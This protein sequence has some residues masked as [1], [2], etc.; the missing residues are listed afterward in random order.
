MNSQLLF[1]VTLSAPSGVNSQVR[2]TTANGTALAGSDYGA[3]DVTLTIRAGS[4]TASLAVTVR[5]DAV[6]EPDE[7]FAVVASAPVNVTLADGEAVGTIL[8]DD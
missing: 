7:T 2:L 4:T 5:G 1:T 3:K 6:D 8:D